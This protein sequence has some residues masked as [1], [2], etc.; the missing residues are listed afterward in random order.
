LLWQVSDKIQS[1]T[2]PL[3]TNCYKILGVSNFFDES[4]IRKAYI[5]LAKLHHPDVAPNSDGER[6][7]II[8]KAYDTLSDKNTRYYHDVKLRYYLE[9][10]NSRTTQR[11][12]PSSGTRKGQKKPMSRA[13]YMDRK[14]RTERIKLRMDMLFYQRQNNRLPYPARIFGWAVVSFVGWQ[15]VYSNW[16]VDEESYDHMFAVLG[17]FLFVFASL[18]MYSHLYKMYRFRAY[19]GKQK[20]AYLRKSTITWLAFLC[21]GLTIL[22]TLNAYRKSYHLKHYGKNAIVSYSDVDGLGEIEI[23]F[24]PIGA[25]KPIVK[26]MDLNENVICDEQHHWVLIRFSKANPRI[27]ELVERDSP[28]YFPAPLN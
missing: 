15:Q 18:G 8:S 25:Q 19:S 27:M 11:Q 28:Y 6:F 2:S 10:G 1:K 9:T 17:F 7:K 5:K 22:P 24:T 16:F 4:L 20:F 21:I 12:S 13:E 14:A 26:R 3:L 23:L